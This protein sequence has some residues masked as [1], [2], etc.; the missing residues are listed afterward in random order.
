MRACKTIGQRGVG[1]IEGIN[2]KA[3][4]KDNNKLNQTRLHTAQVLVRSPVT[5][6]GNRVYEVFALTRRHRLISTHDLKEHNRGLT[7]ISSQ[8]RRILKTTAVDIVVE[9]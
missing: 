1:L 5:D 3:Q 9:L 7:N 8:A 2:A 4:D 6:T